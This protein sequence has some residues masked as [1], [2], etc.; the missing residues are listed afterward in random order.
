MAQ[1]LMQKNIFCSQL[2]Y[3]LRNIV[4]NLD[5]INVLGFNY[6]TPERK[7]D[8]AD[9]PAALYQGGNIDI[10]HTVDGTIRWWLEKG[11]PGENNE[12]ESQCEERRHNI[13]LPNICVGY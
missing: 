5:F 13:G 7:P 9:Y 1:N 11:V 2:Y 10:N 12:L 3:D 8:E 4:P 6:T